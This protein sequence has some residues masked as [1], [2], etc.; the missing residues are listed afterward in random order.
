MIKVL[1]KISEPGLRANED[2]VWSNDCCGVVLDGSTSLIPTD[3]N[4]IWFVNEFITA[5]SA[6][7]DLTND[8]CQSV[9]NALKVV[10]E[11]FCQTF[12]TA[13]MDYYPSASA[14]FVYSHHNKIQ[15]LNI[16][17]CTIRLFMK[18]QQITDIYT[19]DVERLDRQVI[20]EMIKIRKQTSQNICEIATCAEI[21]EMLI[22]NRKKMN[23]PGGYKILS[24]NMPPCQECDTI[25]FD[26]TEIDRI[27]LFS[28]GF[29]SVE[30]EL[31]TPDAVLPDVYRKLR[32]L[33]EHDSLLNDNPRFKMSDDASALVVSV[34]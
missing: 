17:D 20:D 32:A 33:E 24:F 25:E 4:A 11:K 13:E 5:F 16:G 26:S 14:A 7:I 23:A 31:M 27:I 1:Q 28:D 21:K 29:A 18:N 30:G 3:F 10:F 2:L 8:L 19:D 6:Y 22:A 12:T 34:Q 15:I 9:N